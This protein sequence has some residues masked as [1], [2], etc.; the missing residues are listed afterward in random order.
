MNNEN[1]ETFDMNV[2][3]P[4]SD[5]DFFNILKSTG[6]EFND[7]SH[8]FMGRNIKH[9]ATWGVGYYAVVSVVIRPFLI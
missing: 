5:T 8:K 2:L 1:P 4:A 9:V 6:K 7:A 3:L